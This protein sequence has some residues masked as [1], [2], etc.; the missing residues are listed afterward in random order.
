MYRPKIVNLGYDIRVTFPRNRTPA[1]T[2]LGPISQNLSLV[3]RGSRHRGLCDVSVQL[4]D[5]ARSSWANN[6]YPIDL[7]DSVGFLGQRNRALQAISRAPLKRVDL[8]T[9]LLFPR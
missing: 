1:C 3:D 6:P 9:S 2:G 8:Y 4:D 5:V 7:P